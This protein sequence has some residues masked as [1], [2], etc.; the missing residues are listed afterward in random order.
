LNPQAVAKVKLRGEQS[1][2]KPFFKASD[3]EILKPLKP[4]KPFFLK[5][6]LGGTSIPITA[7]FG[8]LSSENPQNHEKT[9]GK[10]NYLF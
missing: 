7:G 5:A 3:L 8:L 6:I 2:E 1:G 4:L 10:H 9:F